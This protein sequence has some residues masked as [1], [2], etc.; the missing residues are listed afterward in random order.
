MPRMHGYGLVLG[1]LCVSFTCAD[2]A[3]RITTDGRGKRDPVFL[4]ATG[5]ALLYVQLEKP[6]QLRIMKRSFKDGSTA[7]LHENEGRSEFEPSVSADGRLVAFVQNRGNLSLALV[8]QDRTLTQIGE[9]PPG[10]GFSGMHS[11]AF[12]PDGSRV[13]FSYP[14][15]GRQQIYSV[16]LQ[17]QDRQLVVDSEG[18]NNWPNVSADGKTLVFSSSRD[19]DYEIYLADV[20]GS[21]PRRLTYS[22]GQDLRPRFSPEGRRIAFTS[23]RDGNYEIYLMNVDGSNLQRIT[24]HPE[25]DDY[26]TWDPAGNSLIIVRENAGRMDLYRIPVPPF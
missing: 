8:I 1:L 5:E 24:E 17:G 26:A 10:G 18:V 6:T 4:N 9:V 14:E 12:L 19:N 15:D 13:L 22:P 7:P 2:D 3:V 11:P 21:G 16:N 23:N 20:N 25:Q